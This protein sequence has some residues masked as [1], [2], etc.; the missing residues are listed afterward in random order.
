M[1]TMTLDQI[2]TIART[3][4]ITLTNATVGTEIYGCWADRASLVALPS[5]ITAGNDSSG[6]RRARR[7]C[8][9]SQPLRNITDA[10]NSCPSHRGAVMDCNRDR[11]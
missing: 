2:T 9:G 6:H 10:V 11:R 3:L 7:R 1:T 5:A 4:K 8:R